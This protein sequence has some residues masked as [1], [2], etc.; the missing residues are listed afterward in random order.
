MAGPKMSWELSGLAQPSWRPRGTSRAKCSG[1]AGLRQRLEQG[2]REIWPD[3]I[4]FGEKV[5]RVAN[6]L[7]FAVPGIKAQTALIALD[8]EGI[9]VSAG[10]ACTSGTMKF[11]EV[12]RRMGH[13]VM[14]AE[15]AV[16]VSLG[17]TTTRGRNRRLSPGL[18]KGVATTT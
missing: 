15:C 5:P 16:R 10:S 2:L 7:Q 13:D 8:L 1:L 9:A 11:S 3:T 4:I 6:T 17:W 12:I 14:V 18:E